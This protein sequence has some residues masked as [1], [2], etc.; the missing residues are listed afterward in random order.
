MRPIRTMLLA[1]LALSAAGAAA[2]AAQRAEKVLLDECSGNVCLRVTNPG[3]LVLDIKVRGKIDKE[4][5]RSFNI[6]SITLLRRGGVVDVEIENGRRA[7][8]SPK[9]YDARP[10]HIVQIQ[11]CQKEVGT[12]GSS[13]KKPT[14]TDWQT[15]K[16]RVLPRR[17]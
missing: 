12:A 16:F 15:F 17:S 7:S 11:Y 5:A 14:C 1:A 13:M 2:E 4:S 6:R 8:W 10:M 3:D 9:F